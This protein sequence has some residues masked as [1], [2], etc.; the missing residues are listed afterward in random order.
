MFAVLHQLVADNPP[1]QIRVDT[2]RA[3][4]EAWLGMSD[5]I[6]R[7]PDTSPYREKD[8]LNERRRRMDSVRDALQ[9]MQLI[10]Q[11]LRVERAAAYADSNRVMTFLGIP[12]LIALA[13]ALAIISR[14]QLGAVSTTYRGLLEGER[15]A[16]TLVETQNWVRTQHMKVSEAVQGDPSAD[17]LGRRALNQLCAQIGAV[18]GSFFV[19]QPGGFKRFANFGLS[20]EIS[21]WFADG[22][23]LVGRAAQSKQ[24]LHVNDVPADFVKVRSG[25]GERTPAEAAA[26]AGVPRG[27][28]PRGVGVRV[29]HAGRRAL[30]GAFGARRRDDRG[31]PCARCSRRSAY[32]IC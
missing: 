6:V 31:R 16:R 18:A 19:A 3:R 14:R 17:E 27:S 28:G 29:F 13:T 25:S 23:G 12:L 24:L 10:E 4:Y 8:A 20:G 21:D 32:P 9:Q 30:A 2:A 22:E 1:Q 11:G 26:A 15:E 7:T 5:V